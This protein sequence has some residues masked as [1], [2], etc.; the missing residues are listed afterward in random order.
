MQKKRG[1]STQTLIVNEMS[2]LND[3]IDM[4]TNKGEFMTGGRSK[5]AEILKRLLPYI[6]SGNYDED[7]RYIVFG[8]PSVWDMITD[9]TNLPSDQEDHSFEDAV[10]KLVSDSKLHDCTKHVAGRI[11][12][13]QAPKFKTDALDG[14]SAEQRHIRSMRRW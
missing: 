12:L 10:S 2:L 6:N 11:S 5:R 7:G 9:L 4:A 1:P 3:F 14:L 13:S 8:A